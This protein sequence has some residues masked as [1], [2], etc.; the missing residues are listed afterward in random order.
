[1]FYERRPLI[2]NSKWYKDWILTIKEDIPPKPA[3]G[4]SN[5]DYVPPSE[6]RTKLSNFSSVKGNSGV[7]SLT[8]W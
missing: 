3:T 7:H 5:S 4:D 6:Y 2:A 8:W 1:M